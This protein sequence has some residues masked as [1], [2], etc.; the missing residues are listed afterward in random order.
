MTL[1][2]RHSFP[3]DIIREILLKLPVESLLRCKSACKEWYSLISDQHFIKSH[4]TLSSTNNINYAHHRLIYNVYEQKNDL[5]SCPLYD[6]L[7][8]ES[9]NNALLLENPLR[10]T[11][12]HNRVRIVGSCNGLV[13]L[14][15]DDN[16]LFIYNPCTR[17]INNI[18]PWCKEGASWLGIFYGFGYDE[19]THDYKVVKIWRSDLTWPSWNTMIYSLKTQSWKDISHFPSHGP[20]T[21]GKFLNGALHWVDRGSSRDIVSLDLG[22][23]TYGEFLQP[24]YAKGSKKLTLGVLGE[25]LC[26]LCNYYESCVVDVWVMKVYGVKDSWTK[27]L[28]ITHPNDQN[29]IPSYMDVHAPLSIS[30]DGKLLLQLGTKLVVCDCINGSC[31]EIQNFNGFCNVCIVVESLISPFAP[32]SIG[33]NN[34][35]EN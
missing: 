25:W 11:W 10:R 33:D 14:S 17:T 6:V 15:A 28:S 12:L 30:N 27:L 19:M 9:A 32:L 3:P 7:F 31:L 8:D 23:E 34:G 5:Y 18:L 21:H 1:E 20:F 24:E 22:K 13:C 35:N 26:V 29:S 2:I 4:Y 16:T